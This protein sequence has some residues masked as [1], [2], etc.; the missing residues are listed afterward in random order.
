[1]KCQRCAKPATYH[2]TEVESGAVEDLHLC[3]ECARQHLLE[4]TPSPTPSPKPPTK[5]TEEIS[6][7]GEKHCETCGI[8][9][10]DFRNSG[11]LG[12]PHDYAV[13]RTE[14]VPLFDNIHGDTKHVGKQPR[15]LPQLKSLL[16]ELGHLRRQLQ[17]AIQHEHYEEAAQLRDRIKQLET[18]EEQPTGGES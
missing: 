10:V 13:F 5:K 1:M 12:C 9:F 6:E 2:I 18:A 15:R 7:L 11:R 14:L 3:E 16:Q 8:K 17:A 4:P